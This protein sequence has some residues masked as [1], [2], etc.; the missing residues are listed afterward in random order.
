MQP[1][2]HNGASNLP[3]G[4]S[5]HGHRHWSDSDE[6]GERG[7]RQQYSYDNR[8]WQSMIIDLII[9]SFSTINVTKLFSS[10]C[11]F[12][13]Q[14]PW[15]K[16]RDWGRRPSRRLAH[17]R[18]FPILAEQENKGE[19]AGSRGAEYWNNEAGAGRERVKRLAG[20][21]SHEE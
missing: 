21:V 5:H 6:F 11:N 19:Y 9:T 3:L 20:C 10:K 17:S 14:R 15:H 16:D 2:K 7:C 1:N 8:I 18:P 4:Y 12:S 13:E